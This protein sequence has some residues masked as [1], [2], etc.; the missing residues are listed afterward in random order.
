VANDHVT[1]QGELPGIIRMLRK[2]AGDDTRFATLE[3]IE[4]NR[5]AFLARVHAT[6]KHI[7][8][9]AL[10]EL[11][12]IENIIQSPSSKSFP[13]GFLAFLQ[14]S[15]SIW[16]RINDALVWSML[17]HKDHYIRRLCHR[18][19]R[20]S[21]L[22]ANPVALRRLIDNLNEDPQTF[23]LWSD[24]TS[25]IDVGD[26]ICR[27]F[28]GGLDGILE[29]KEGKVN[30]QILDLMSSCAEQET[31]I[32]AIAAFVEKY[33]AKGLQQI[34]RMAKQ[35]RRHNQV[36]DILESDRG[37]DPHHEQYVVVRDANTPLESYDVRL[38]EI[39]EEPIE[40][41]VLRCID[42]CLWVYIDRDP[43][44]S[45]G[46]RVKS[47]SDRL[48]REAPEA[49][50]WSRDH[51]SS[52]GLVD[53]VPLD[54][55]LFC[56]EAIPLVLRQLEPDTIRD[57]IVGQL[58][59]RVLLHVDWKEY[60]RIVEGLGA[61]LIW[62]STKAGR[63]QRA[64]PLAQRLMTV[65]ERIP[66]IQ[67]ADGRYF[68]GQSKIYRALFDGVCPSSIAAQYVEVLKASDPLVDKINEESS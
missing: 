47:F 31:R 48:S 50:K 61:Q 40:T 2:P 59:E 13:P 67:L 19:E 58:T 1:I 8:S 22:H 42:R 20:L 44:K 11:L 34:D 60:G 46:E 27:S 30:H 35:R 4:I 10:D 62:S 55:N 32:E 28:S 5:P 43:S 7:H 54:G 57:V 17:G 68:E 15:M 18:K 39:L 66:R 64:R 38:Q 16:R 53:V 9:R 52:N 21:L 65:G 56:P 63:S 12:N 33:G 41:P 24:A 23:A 6:W 36:L 51:E 29:V 3:D 45:F 26:I 25:C 37:F 14:R 49:W